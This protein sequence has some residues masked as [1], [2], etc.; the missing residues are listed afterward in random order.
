MADDGFHP[1]KHPGRLHR[2]LGIPEDEK[3]P[4]DRLEEA[5]RSKDPE[6]RREA[7]E[8]ET[9]EH[10]WK[11]TGPKHKSETDPGYIDLMNIFAQSR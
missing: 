5:T 3:I 4:Q 6:I 2:Q 7:I 8:A 1:V 9:M 10:K 11:H